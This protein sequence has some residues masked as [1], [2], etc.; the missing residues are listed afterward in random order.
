MTPRARRDACLAVLELPAGAT[1]VEI[2]RAY[3]RLCKR[4]HPD[5]FAGDPVKTE[6]AN[7]LLAEI[8]AAYAYL[9]HAVD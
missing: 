6:M 4:Y 9:R 2:V 8:N 7:E 1:R 5:G 3:R